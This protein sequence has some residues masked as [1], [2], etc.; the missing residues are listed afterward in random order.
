MVNSPC[1]LYILGLIGHYYGK[2]FIIQIYDAY[3]QQNLMNGDIPWSTISNDLLVVQMTGRTAPATTGSKHNL[4]IIYTYLV[5]N[6]R[7]ISLPN[8]ALKQSYNTV[9]AVFEVF[10]HSAPVTISLSQNYRHR[11]QKRNAWVPWKCLEC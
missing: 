10:Y 1:A 3:E 8:T 7:L 6:A 5:Y 4:E 2:Q 11:S 9:E